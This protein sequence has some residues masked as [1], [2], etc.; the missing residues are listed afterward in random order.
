M[1]HGAWIEREAPLARCPLNACNRSGACRHP[2]DQ[3]PCRR[4]YETKE[5]MRLAL[6]RKLAGLA[7]AAR[8]RDPEVRNY[9]APGTPEFERRL[10]LIYEAV[11]AADAAH[12]AA[13]AAERRRAKKKPASAQGA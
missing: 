2:T 4:L 11:R 12:C 5:A 1:L 10:K 3:D 7:R 9:A 13:E 8:R 6:A